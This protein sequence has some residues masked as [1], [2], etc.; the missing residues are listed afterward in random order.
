MDPHLLPSL[1]LPTGGTARRNGR[2]GLPVRRGLAGPLAQPDPTRGCGPAALEAEG[3][4]WFFLVGWLP[5][6][7]GK[8]PGGMFRSCRMPTPCVGPVEGV[9]FLQKKISGGPSPRRWGG[10]PIRI[11]QHLKLVHQ[12]LQCHFPA[13]PR[14]SNANP[15]IRR[16]PD[17]TRP[18]AGRR[19]S[20]N[21][22]DRHQ[23]LL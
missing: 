17:G 11:I 4:L 10:R 8:G 14:E 1:P 6:S 7:P 3:S 5:P 22:L 15:A 18:P 13:N 20:F 19:S 2:G 9:G 23:T 12:I 21:G 16:F